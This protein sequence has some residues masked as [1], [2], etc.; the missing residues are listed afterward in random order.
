MNLVESLVEYRLTGNPFYAI[1]A[2]KK[3]NHS[4]E[5]TN[6]GTLSLISQTLFDYRLMGDLGYAIVAIKKAT[7]D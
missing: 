7:H 4:S 2:T 5:T 6:V 1:I 3:V